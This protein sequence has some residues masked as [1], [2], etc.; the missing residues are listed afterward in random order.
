[1]TGKNRQHHKVVS[2]TRVI[3]APAATIFDLVA[4]P[5]RHHMFDGSG[6]VNGGRRSN[7]TR[8]ELGSKFSMDM[9]MFVPYRI[10]N[11]VVDFEE[12][13]VIAWRHLGHHE[14]RYELR[15]IDDNT[16]EVTESFDWGKARF[17]AAL[18]ELVNYPEKNLAG[19]KATLE[20]LAQVVEGS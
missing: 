12:G 14:W 6:T 7:P 1:M 8:L 11:E 13:R 9:R 19:I 18:Y 16:T 3:G 5:A 15:P 2:A 10:S 17:P 20:R 4:D